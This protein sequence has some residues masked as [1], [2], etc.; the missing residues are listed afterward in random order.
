[1]WETIRKLFRKIID[2]LSVSGDKA[3]DSSET[4]QKF[5]KVESTDFEHSVSVDVLENSPLEKEQMKNGEVDTLDEKKEQ[6]ETKHYEHKITEIDDSD[7][8]TDSEAGESG[9]LIFNNDDELDEVEIPEKH[10]LFE[11]PSIIGEEI[12]IIEKHFFDETIED[13][14]S[15]DSDD[16]EAVAE[17]I[18]TVVDEVDQIPGEGEGVKVKKYPTPSIEDNHLPT[19]IITKKVERKQKRKYFYYDIHAIPILADEE[20]DELIRLAEAGMLKNEFGY[21]SQKLEIFLLNA[22][23][24]YDLIG[25]IPFGRKSFEY[26]CDLIQKCYIKNNRTKITQ[27]PPALFIATMVFCARYSEEEAR[28]FWKPYADI[29]WMRESAQ[30]FQNISRKHFIESKLFLQ[31]YFEFTFPTIKEGDVVRPVYYQAVIPYYLQSNFAEWLVERFE[32]LLVFSID[33][34]P[35]VLRKEKSLDYVPPRLRNFVRQDETSDAA[36]KLIRQMAKAVRLFQTTEQYETVV[37]VMSSPIER[38]LWREIYQNLIEKQLKLEKVRKHTPKLEWVWNLDDNDINL[39]LSQVRASKDEKPNLIIWAKKGSHY[40]RDEEILL[41]VHPWQ[42]ANGD[43]E[44]ETEFI[45]DTGDLGGKIYVLSEEFDFE[46]QLSNQDDHIIL[47]KEIPEIENDILFFF[48]SAHRS[49]AKEKEIINL[50]G[51]WVILSKDSVDI[52]D[53][54]DEKCVFENIYIPPLLRESGFNLAKKYSLILPITLQFQGEKTVFQHPQTS[55]VMQAELLGEKQIENLSSNIQPIFQTSDIRMQLDAEFIQ[56][57]LARTWVSVHRGGVFVNSISL[58][59]LQKKK[60]FFDDNGYIISLGEFIDEPGSYSVNIL[61]DLQLLLEEDLRFAY[62]PNV[63]IVGP[64]SATCYSP[65]HPPEIIISG[66]DESR[67]KTGI[68]EK[69]KVSESSTSIHLIWKEVRLPKCRFSLQWEGNNVNFSWDISRVSAWI[70]GGGDKKNVLAGQEQNVI[71]NARGKSKEEIVWFIKDTELRRKIPLDY[72][73]EYCRGLNQSGLRDLLKSSKLALSTVAISIRDH[74]WDVFVYNKIPSLSFKSVGYDKPYIRIAISQS[75]RLE[76]EFTIQI[77]D[78]EKPIKP[79]TISR[80]K[81]LEENSKFKVDLLPGKYQIE[82]LLGN[83]ILAVSRVIVVKETIE[84]VRIPEKEILITQDEKFTAQK[85]FDSLTSNRQELLSIKDKYHA[86]RIAILNQLISINSYDTWVT[87]E[88]LDD[89]LKRL[90]PSWAVLQYPLRFHTQKHNRIF[91]IFPQQVAFGAKAGKGYMSAKLEHNPVNI[92]AAWNS[93]LSTNK[94]RLWLM[95]PQDENIK[96]FCELDEWTDLWPAYQCVDC[97]M[98]VGSKNGNYIKLSPQ[99]TIAHKHGK[100][101]SIR[102]QFLDVVYDKP[103][104][105]FVE[106]EVKI[107]QYQ[108]KKLSHYYWPNEVVGGNYFNDL[109]DGRM[110]PLQGDISVPIGTF[111]A[112]D[113]YIAISEVYQNYKN[114]KYRITLQQIIGKEKLF[115]EIKDFVFERKEEVPAFSAALRLD[116]QILS[117]QRLYFLPKYVLLL[118]LV[119]RL[120][121]HNPKL[122][123]SL[124]DKD[125]IL[126]NEII[127]LTFQAMKSCPKLLEWSIAW[128][129]IFFNHTIS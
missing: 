9:S 47:E 93:D 28:N 109:S 44:L 65:A 17:V 111:K 116:Q 104:E 78:T 34:L 33:D 91:H 77:R 62:L 21:D 20:I 73:G 42:L 6:I 120:K 41:D 107:S 100:I 101:R 128:V 85:L 61:H 123:K 45:S 49:I 98:I 57:Q 5:I 117:K 113:Y 80:A 18:E 124:L 40:L 67:I 118:S 46:E 84:V 88:K 122:Y 22:Y 64:N 59:E 96:A 32:Q 68:D 95:I 112:T 14:D 99:T 86:N 38:S 26:F 19:E 97:G 8:P 24:R 35:H 82:I 39:Q 43:W 48:I 60:L 36:A 72:Q 102:E 25:E 15:L 7:M 70:D 55:F 71:L 92:Y 125:D 83:E 89:G 126:E 66:V 105:R 54:A 2:F 12:A 76:G 53:H 79:I 13:V 11:D 127:S 52:L 81:H 3:S 103:I 1:M 69:I 37:S 30:Y 23:K 121:S 58:A 75:E 27:V 119:L 63:N 4:K 51:D 29:V 114:P 16:V 50:N 110:R 74:I 115:K 90:L 106:I 31:K 94:T 129:E 56:H 108:E 10:E 87:K